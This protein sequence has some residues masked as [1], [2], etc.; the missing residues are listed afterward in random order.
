MK[1][2]AENKMYYATED[3]NIYSM[4]RHAI[5][6]PASVGGYLQIKMIENGRYKNFY[7]HRLI[8]QTFI[9]NPDNKPTVNHKN[10]NKSDNR[11]E[12]LEWA[13]YSEN[14]RHAWKNG[15]C[16]GGR[17]AAKI[18]GTTYHLIGSNSKRKKIMNVD[19]GEVF[20]S[21]KLAGDS[22]GGRV[23]VDRKYYGFTWRLI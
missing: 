22:V 19:T 18:I 20:E 9:P 5:M 2:I 17:A 4:H 13:S 1:Q 16:E 23:G 15:R 3:G 21:M 8:A 11:V 6:S 14:C 10:C 7:V 12:N